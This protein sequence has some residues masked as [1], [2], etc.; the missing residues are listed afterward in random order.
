MPCFRAYAVARSPSRLATATSSTSSDA[1]MPGRSLRLMLAVL[2]MPQ[3]TGSATSGS[4]RLGATPPR[5]RVDGDREQQH[6]AGDD[7]LRAGAQAQQAEPVVDRAD[8]ESSEHG[9]LH[10]AAT[11]EQ[12]RA[13]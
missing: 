10:V 8:H 4:A 7:K 9:A 11:A 3:R 12:A 1:R 2:R 5:D 13:A 6:G